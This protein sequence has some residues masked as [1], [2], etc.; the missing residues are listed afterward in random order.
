[1]SEAVSPTQAI[2]SAAS[3]VQEVVD[4]L[5]RKIKFRKLRVLDQTKLMRI[6]GGAN[7]ANDSFFGFA[8]IAYSVISIGDVP[9]PVPHDMRSLDA[10]IERLDDEGYNA[11]SEYAQAMIEAKEKEAVDPAAVREEAKN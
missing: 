10:A 1:M 7:A 3:G 11:I 6:V 5:G 8:S 9:Y 4:S 2:V